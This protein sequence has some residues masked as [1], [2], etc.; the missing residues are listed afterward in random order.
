MFQNFLFESFESDFLKIE[1][2]PFM[3]KI[4]KESMLFKSSVIFEAR[5]S[6]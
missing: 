4:L 2:L 5:T 6:I 1:L 3:N